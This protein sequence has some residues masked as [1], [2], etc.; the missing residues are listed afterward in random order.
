MDKWLPMEKREERPRKSWHE[1]VKTA[2]RKAIFQLNNGQIGMSVGSRK[3]H[4][5][6]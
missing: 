6:F 1:G 5:S 3:W 4:Q 2:M